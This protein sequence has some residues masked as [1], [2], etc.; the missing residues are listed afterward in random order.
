MIWNLSYLIMRVARLVIIIIVGMIVV[1]VLLIFLRLLI[2][3]II[4]VIFLPVLLF[5]IGI[6]FFREVTTRW[7]EE[8]IQAILDSI[9]YFL[10]GSQIGIIVHVIHQVVNGEE[11]IH[12]RLALGFK[13]VILIPE[14]C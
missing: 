10:Q 9:R 1:V 2:I 13:G 12:K 3:F 11:G 6:I 4:V 7:F 5:V 14:R 8:L